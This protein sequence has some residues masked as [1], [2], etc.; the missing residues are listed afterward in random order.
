MLPIGPVLF[1]RGLLDMA[2]RPPH[3]LRTI[4]SMMSPY[5]RAQ[6]SPAAIRALSRVP[7]RFDNSNPS[8]GQYLPGAVVGEPGSIIMGRNPNQRL[9]STIHMHEALHAFDFMRNQYP[10]RRA[11]QST[12][13]DRNLYEKYYLQSRTRPNLS[14]STRIQEHRGIYASGADRSA[15]EG[16]PPGESYAT[17]GMLGPEGIPPYIDMF[18]LYGDFFNPEALRQAAWNRN[19]GR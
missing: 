8:A 17:A 14:P 19:H 4:L 11:A 16:M 7:V 3:P 6:L 5:Q 9:P 2:P 18:R 15:V 13:G 12:R 1:S 10:S